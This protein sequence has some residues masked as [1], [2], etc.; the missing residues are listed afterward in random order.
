MT[1]DDL[2]FASGTPPPLGPAN[3]KEAIL[4][5]QAILRAFVR[6]GVPATGFVIEQ[7][8]EQLGKHVSERI[9]REWIRPGF[10]LGNHLYSH[11]DANALTV[12]QIKEEIRRGEIS[13]APLLESISRKPKFLR[14]PFNHTGDTKEKHDAVMAYMSLRGYRLA[15]CTIDNS[16]FEFNNT[17]VRARALHDGNAISRLRADYI[18]Y[19]AREIDWYTA[20]DKTVFGYEPPHIMLVHDNALNADTIENV[21]SL[22]RQRG[23]A[24]ITLSEALKDPA[25]A[26]SETYVTRFGPMWGY[27]WAKEL[28]VT[29]NGRGEPD[30]PAWIGRYAKD[31]STDR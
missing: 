12:E 3:A 16:D 31:H 8:D 2:P 24:F 18:T 27:R 20:L 11:S 29:V 30:P 17:Y 28:Q 10:D 19:T 5:N 7:R 1:V 23:Y 22:F 9:L 6:H 25:Y 21:L 26:V 4:V 15:P 13:F 14:F